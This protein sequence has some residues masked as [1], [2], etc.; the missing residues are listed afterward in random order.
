[1]ARF[2]LIPALVAALAGPAHA[3]ILRYDNGEVH[4]HYNLSEGHAEGM[5]LTTTHPARL[6]SITLHFGAVDPVEV[7]VWA[8]NGGQQPELDFEVD[9]IEPVRTTPDENGVVTITIDPPVEIGPGRHFHVGHKMIRNGGPTLLIDTSPDVELSRAMLYDYWAE[10]DRYIWYNTAID[11]DG[12]LQYRHYL[13]YAEV[14]YHDRVTE[15]RFS[16]VTD[17]VGLGRHRTVAVVD[18]DGDGDLDLLGGRT[19]F[20][21]TSGV[22]TDISETAL[23][24]VDHGGG[25]VF[26]DH[27]R[28][29]DLDLLIWESSCCNETDTGGQHDLLMVNQGGVYTEKAD[30]GLFDYYPQQ[31]AAWGDYDNDG[32]PDMFMPGYYYNPGTG[33]QYKGD[34]LFHNNGDGTFSDSS[35]KLHGNFPALP[36]RT[37]TWADFDQDGWLDLFVGVYRLKPNRHYHNAGGANLVDEAEALGTQGVR[38]EGNY[39]HAIGS[40]WGDL[41][42]DGDLDLVV[43]NLAHPRFIDFSDKSA[44]WLNQHDAG[45]LGFVDAFAG[46]GVEYRETASG[47]ALGDYDND[48]DLDLFQTNVYVGRES[49][50]WKSLLVETGELKFEEASYEA[51]VLVDNGW[52]AVFADMDDDGDL[53]LVA[54]GL[55]RNQGEV[56][57]WLKVRLVGGEGSDTHGLGATVTV[58]AGD[59][60]V[61][62]LV[63]AGQSIGCQGPYELHFGLGEHSGYDSITVRWLGGSIDEH[64]CGDGN[65]KLALTQ[66]ELLPEPAGGCAADSDADSDADADGDVDADVDAD[67]EGCGCAAGDATPAS[68]AAM[69]LAVLVL[70]WRRDGRR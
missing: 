36:S 50:L 10:F 38:I 8:D 57:N 61:T 13:A 25:G 30:A 46:S 3:E 20:E 26:A 64:P 15:K 31:S 5:R 53:D 66:G 22:F 6:T 43:M 29:G 35:A 39:G 55:W 41:D 1:M 70:L 4:G 23:A 11:V 52:G 12:E 59:L 65:Q 58:R 34:T 67:D 54:S 51:G 47:P 48:G 56:G 63:A 2:A 49:N 28:D 42:N 21:N 68:A 17:E 33:E 27:D 14:E 69:L 62:R 45:G 18:H 44:L 24:G 7:H 16:D 37:V 9:L 40:E 32:Y 60:A 19:L